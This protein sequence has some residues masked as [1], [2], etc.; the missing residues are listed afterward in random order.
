MRVI[1]KHPPRNVVRQPSVVC[2]LSFIY[3][4]HSVDSSGWYYIASYFDA[5]YPLSHKRLSHIKQ[6]KILLS[7]QE[8]SSSSVRGPKLSRGITQ[9][10]NLSTTP[11]TAS[12]TKLNIYLLQF[13]GGFIICINRCLLILYGGGES[14]NISLSLSQSPPL[15]ERIKWYI[16]HIIRFLHYISIPDPRPYAVPTAYHYGE[17]SHYILYLFSALLFRLI[18]GHIFQVFLY[19][20]RMAVVFYTFLTPLIYREFFTTYPPLY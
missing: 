14:L 19:D 6:Y 15:R 12:P 3:L 8:T 18:R 5:G 1:V 7:Y 10:I 11:L 13:Q 9:S 16:W 2:C 20:V 4:S 17:I